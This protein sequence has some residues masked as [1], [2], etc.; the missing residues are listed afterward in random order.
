[1]EKIKAFI[2]K[3]FYAVGSNMVSLAVSVLSALIVP[4]FFG[5]DI[6]QY[7]Y[8]QIFI[9]YVGY[10]GFFH[11]G[12]CDGVFLRYG[13]KSYSELNKP[14]CSSQFIL[15]SAAQLFIAATIAVIGLTAAPDENY[16]KIYL[17]VAISIIIVIPR[18]ML[19]MFLQ[20]TNRIKEYASI[21]TA[22]RLT[23]GL[24]ILFIFIFLPKNFEF[25]V[26]G[27]VTG[28]LISLLIAAWYCRD[29]VICKPAGL[30]AA[31]AEA[32]ENITVGIKLMLANIAG[33]LILGIVQFGIQ[34]QWSVETYAKTSLSL[35]VSNL[36]LAFISAVALV[37]Y[38]TLRR[39]EREK[40]PKIYLLLRD[41][42]MVFL[43]GVLIVYYPIRLILSAWLPQYAEGLRYLAI[44]FP[45]CVYAAQMT[46]LIQTYMNVYRL[47]K[48]FLKVNVIGVAIALATTAVTVFVLKNLTLAMLT[49]V[50]N[51]MLRCIIAEISLAKELHI[52]VAKSIC[53]EAALTALFICSGW[54]IGGWI[55]VLVYAAGV[56]IYAISKKSRIKEIC[57]F[58]KDG[59]NEYNGKV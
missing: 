57:K 15:L 50:V 32:K 46:M 24:F 1:M 6:S 38:P 11:F 44:L 29:M 18:T 39:V 35:S 12:W 28:E 34:T 10:I 36:L 9:F 8:Y 21:T 47:E 53:F 31:L 22:N 59:V 3:V 51:Q 41:V 30:N 37:L 2:K 43:F 45:M 26:V 58:V 27:N 13:G 19:T 14:L 17:A 25:F 4:K 52:G 55:S 5:S 16:R 20:A 54:F 42:L 33:M 23:Y 40:L 48:L 7:G 49:I 56:L